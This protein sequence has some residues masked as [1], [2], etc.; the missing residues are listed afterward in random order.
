MALLHCLHRLAPRWEL[1]LSAAHLN[2]RL[3]GEESDRDEGFVR[4]TCAKLGVPFCSEVVDVGE[5]A[6]AAKQNLEETAREV[7]YEFLRRAAN[8]VG[9]QKIALGHTLND[10][11]ETV[12]MRFLRGS[13]T[14][15]LAA[16]HPVVDRLMIRPLLECT[17][18]NILEYLTIREIPFRE[19]S[20][21]SELRFSRN[22]VRRELI[23][24]LERHFN[25]RLADTLAREAGLA[26]EVAGYLEAQARSVL[27]SIRIRDGEGLALPVRRILELHPA[28]QKWVVRFALRECR[29]DL[30]GITARHIDA[31]HALCRPLHSGR[32]I[33][34]PGGSVAARQFGNILFMEREPSPQPGFSYSLPIP[35]WCFVAEAG[36]EFSTAV[37]ES[38]TNTDRSIG[39][40]EF[41][42]VLE[43]ASLPSVLTIRSRRPGD[44]YGGSRHRKV[45][46]MLIDAK[47]PLNARSRFPVVVAGDAVIWMPG[48]KPAKSYIP[49]SDSDRCVIIE[50][51]GRTAR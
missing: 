19:D 5:R 41:R 9:A 12:L 29:G 15:G 7:R 27:E 37:V 20:S 23:P 49:Q 51:H 21:N 10:Q 31:V 40:G 25:P 50:A 43:A 46:K 33:K 3:R 38:R 42:A 2:H 34:L 8:Q 22:R 28:L 32:R 4:D 48:F 35:G 18:G 47:V 6:A 11:A 30:R 44:R 26:R 17:R 1:I 45:K 36:L 16:I 39:L 13:G 14:E 24:Y